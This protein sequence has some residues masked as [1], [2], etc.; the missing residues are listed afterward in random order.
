MSQQDSKKKLLSYKD[1]LHNNPVHIDI[2]SILQ[3]SY[4]L[5]DAVQTARE[6]AA[7]DQASKVKKTWTYMGITLAALI[8]LLAAF[9]LTHRRK[10]K[11]DVI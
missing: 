9:L 3:T 10:L 1:A 6:Q 4:A 5:L 8:L 11:S 7:L 2:Y